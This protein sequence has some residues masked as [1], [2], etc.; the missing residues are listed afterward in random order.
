MDSYLIVNLN[1]VPK[2]LDIFSVDNNK[3][4]HLEGCE[5][6]EPVIEIKAAYDENSEAAGSDT[7]SSDTNSR[8]ET[9]SAS[10]DIPGAAVSDNLSESG[11][12]VLVSSIKSALSKL[13]TKWTSSAVIFAPSSYYSCNIS[14]PF[15]DEKTISKVLR[16]EI[17]DLLSFGTEDF[18]VDHKV[19]GRLDNGEFD[20]HLAMAD[21]NELSDLINQCNA[22]GIDPVAITPP[23]ALLQAP[24]PVAC[25]IQLSSHA[26]NLSFLIS[27]QL[28]SDRSL[29][30][31]DLSSTDILAEIK[32]SILSI[33]KR[34][35]TEFKTVYL[36]SDKT[37]EIS[38]QIEHVILTSG[39]EVIH[40]ETD[41]ANAV[42]S[43]LASNKG[44]AELF[45]NFRTGELAKVLSFANIWQILKPFMPYLLLSI[46]LVGAAL[47][48]TYYQKESEIDALQQDINAK[49]AQILGVNQIASGE[50]TKTIQQSIQTIEKQLSEIGSPAKYSPLEILARLSADFST[51]TLPKLMNLSIKSS[52]LVFTVSSDSF[53]AID[54]IEKVLNSNKQ[55]YCSFERKDSGSG[56]REFTFTVKLC[57]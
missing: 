42:T 34:Y 29:K 53:A 17:E 23:P 32:R 2:R 11:G 13:T 49:A 40:H 47:I 4:D 3:V 21:K 55:F 30:T 25:C 31:T 50:V 1:S 15:N 46:I 38:S 7:D 6:E 22:C 48:A 39:K 41:S 8:P 37:S 5:I 10:T 12:A 57:E 18:I 24:D 9:E 28:R 52:E 43:V 36:L 45:V 16:S 35:Q 14:L 27:G 51:T 56:T 44:V 19:V 20:V 33:E 54:P 26:V